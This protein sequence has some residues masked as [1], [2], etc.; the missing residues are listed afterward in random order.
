MSRGRIPETMH[1]LAEGRSLGPTAPLQYQQARGVQWPASQAG[2]S[3]NWSGRGEKPGYM[4]SSNFITNLVMGKLSSEKRRREKAAKRAAKE[5]GSSEGTAPSP[6]GGAAPTAPAGG[7]AA[8]PATGGTAAAPQAS[9]GV[10]AYI[11]PSMRPN[12]ASQRRGPASQGGSPMGNIAGADAGAGLARPQ[13]PVL[14]T[15]S[16][17][18]A[19]P[20]WQPTISQNATKETRSPWRDRSTD[21]PVPKVPMSRLTGQEAYVPPSL[22]G[23]PVRGTR[24]QSGANLPPFTAPDSWRRIAPGLPPAPSPAAGNAARQQ[25][26]IPSF[27]EILSG[28]GVTPKRDTEVPL[29][30]PPTLP[31][32]PLGGIVGSS[33]TAELATGAAKKPRAPRAPRKP[34][35]TPAEKP[36]AKAPRGKGKQ[37]PK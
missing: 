22:R 11:P 8:A 15:Y 17:Q 29:D 1:S 7:A 27:S 30:N 9:A 16:N 10:P 26:G 2:V 25:L 21:A 5:G 37:N 13:L 35:E 20:N 18:A 14:P 31:A 4:G 6:L 12:K 24:P 28:Q 34:K 32:T 3:Q 19:N 33:K 36:A 23:A